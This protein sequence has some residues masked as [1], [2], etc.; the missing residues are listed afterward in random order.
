LSYE[1]FW[2]DAAQKI[3]RQK[4]Q[5]KTVLSASLA[6]LIALITTAS[7]FKLSVDPNFINRLLGKDAPIIVSEENR[8]LSTTIAEEDGY[9]YFASDQG[10]IGLYKFNASNP[11]DYT[12]LTSA[13]ILVEH[14]I[15]VK[16]GWIYY[17]SRQGESIVTICK[18]RVDGKSTQNVT[19]QIRPIEEKQTLLMLDNWIYFASDEGYGY[20]DARVNVETMKEEYIEYTKP[21]YLYE[22]AAFQVKNINH[23]GLRDKG[24]S[25]NGNLLTKHEISWFVVDGEWLYFSE[26][27]NHNESWV[28]MKTDGSERSVIY[29][30]FQ[31]LVDY[32]SGKEAVITAEGKMVYNSFWTL[33]SFDK[34]N[35]TQRV[36]CDQSKLGVE[37]FSVHGDWVVIQDTNAVTAR[38]AVIKLDGTG[39]IQI[40]EISGLS[41]DIDFWSAGI[42]NGWLY[43]FTDNDQNGEK[44]AMC[45]SLETGNKLKLK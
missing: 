12:R 5:R 19:N 41:R 10:L 7:I 4:K 34:D 32:V 9:T 26:F 44:S 24:L 1:Q 3:Q 33:Y 13:D 21:Y 6:V 40:D 43:Y 20:V 16:N 23:P 22:N 15:L 37:K 31:G 11:T 45:Y 8:A 39:F 25:L 17:T 29:P 38:I 18:T 28:K 2:A 42:S 30:R 35:A 27:R 36:I 14:G